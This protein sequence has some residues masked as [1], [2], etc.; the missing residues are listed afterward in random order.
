M[1]RP[2]ERKTLKSIAIAVLLALLILPT[3]SCITSSEGDLIESVLNNIDAVNGEAIFHTEDGRTIKITVTDDSQENAANTGEKNTDENKKDEE[4]KDTKDNDEK[5]NLSDILPRVDSI[6]NIFRTL[7]LWEKACELH[8][9]GVTWSHTAEELGLS[10]ETMY[11]ELQDDIEDSLRHAKELGLITQ[12]QFEYKF[13]HY[14]ET[15]LKWVNKIFADT[16]E[17]TASNAEDLLA[18]IKSYEDVFKSLG[19]WEKACK[20]NESGLSWGEVATELDL[21]KEI[22]YRELKE[23]IESRLHQAKSNGIISYEQY[24]EKLEYYYADAL[25][26]VTKIFPE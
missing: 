13:K 26:W 4:V 7:G 23:D 19:L 11:R 8:S 25:E 2:T 15:A 5:E 1:K 16:C 14:S 20:L 22:M 24:K 9:N 12:E 17:P 3:T 21:T 6:E 10:S 18:T